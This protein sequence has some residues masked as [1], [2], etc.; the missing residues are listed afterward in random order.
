MNESREF[1]EKCVTLSANLRESFLSANL[2]AILKAARKTAECFA[3]GNRLLLCSGWGG[4]EIAQYLANRFA[5]SFFMQRP[6]LPAFCLASAMPAE[7]DAQAD[8]G[9]IQFRQLEALGNP[10]D[11]LLAFCDNTGNI[12]SSL[13]AGR[14][15]GIFTIGLGFL[16]D[17]LAALCDVAIVAALVPQPDLTE[18][19]LAFANLYGRLADYFLFENP[20]AA[21][22]ATLGRDL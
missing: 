19:Y 4:L 1:L 18:N 17:D 14:E 20:C 15:N 12:A 2:D 13:A 16:P 22:E 6:P 7:E 3:R 21:D 9:K 5:T 8:F 10:G 11:V